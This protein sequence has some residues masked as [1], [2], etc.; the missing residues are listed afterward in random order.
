MDTKILEKIEKPVLKREVVKI[1]IK[2]PGEK[3][4]DRKTVISVA[5]KLLNKSNDLIILKRISTIFGQNKCVAEVHSYKNRDDLEENEPEF[6]IKRNTIK[7]DESEEIVPE[8][9]GGK[10]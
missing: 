6:L 9:E 1:L 7:E 4:P 2:H 10:K 5:S 3:T 8:K